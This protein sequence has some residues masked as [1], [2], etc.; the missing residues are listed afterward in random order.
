MEEIKKDRSVLIWGLP[1]DDYGLTIMDKTWGY[2]ENPLAPVL[3]FGIF[4]AWLYYFYLAFFAMCAMFDRKNIFVYASIFLMLLQRPE[5]YKG[6]PAAAVLILFFTGY[7][8]IKARIAYIRNGHVK[9]TGVL[10]APETD[11]LICR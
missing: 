1:R 9:S 7:E 6:G 2:G 11:T 4:I 8:L 5:F 3:K 10:Y